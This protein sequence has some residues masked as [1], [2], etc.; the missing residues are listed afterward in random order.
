MGEINFLS[1]NKNT[2]NQK[3]IQPKKGDDILWSKAKVDDQADNK[4]NVFNWRN[5]FNKEKEVKG[6]DNNLV[7]KLKI[8]R[9]RQEV[10][11]LIKQNESKSLLIKQ[12][13]SRKPN[14][15]SIF[16]DW[17]ISIFN[18]KIQHQQIFNKEKERKS[19]I[20]PININLLESK[21]DIKE[22]NKIKKVDIYKIKPVEK[23]KPNAETKFSD[24]NLNNI[25]QPKIKLETFPKPA[26]IKKQ[27][28]VAIKPSLS[29][30]AEKLK[31][32]KNPDIVKTNLIKGEIVA[33]FDWKAKIVVLINVI[34]LSCSVVGFAYAGLLFWQKQNIGKKEE[35]IKKNIAQVEQANQAGEKNKEIVIFQN[36]LNATT[37]L[38]NN[39]IY[40]TNFFKFLEENTMPDVYYTGFSGDTGGRYFFNAITKNYAGISKQINAMKA[41]SHVINVKAEGGKIAGRGEKSGINFSLDLEINPDIFTE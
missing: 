2:N 15:L 39:H 41:N 21:P 26:V 22:E 23:N 28:D 35:T 12:E 9:S 20:Q 6:V 29:R 25:Q 36:K 16:N 30:E 31:L 24:I 14:K 17:I 19:S 33:Y 7:N 37:I 34:I 3:K 32:W 11:K 13:H 40:W 10:L 18:K 8:K 38:L 4:K 1:S 5:F 27:E